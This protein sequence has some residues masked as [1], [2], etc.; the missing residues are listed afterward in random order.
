[1]SIRARR[2][3][4]ARGKPVAEN[5]RPGADDLAIEALLVEPR[6][7]LRHRLDRRGKNGR[8]LKP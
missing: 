1:L 3:S 6:A 7:A 4:A 8:T 5:V 2:G